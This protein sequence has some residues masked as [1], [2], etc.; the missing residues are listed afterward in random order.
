M[1]VSSSFAY[2]THTHTENWL[3][4]LDHGLVSSFGGRIAVDWARESMINYGCTIL[5]ISLFFR[6]SSTDVFFQVT[7]SSSDPLIFL[8]HWSIDDQCVLNTK[9][10]TKFEATRSILKLHNQESCLP[11]LQTLPITMMLSIFRIGNTQLSSQYT[12]STKT[13]LW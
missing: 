7:S 4:L 1:C 5:F 6:C 13:R 12:I 11:V 10:I 9:T 2:R 8:Y 3:E